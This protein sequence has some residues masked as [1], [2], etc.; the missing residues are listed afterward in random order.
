MI[1]GTRYYADK[2]SKYR[3]CMHEVHH[4]IMVKIIRIIY[5]HGVGVF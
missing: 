3:E 1:T 4:I 2:Q 5:Q